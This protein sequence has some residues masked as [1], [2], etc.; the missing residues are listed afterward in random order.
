MKKN[1]TKINRDILIIKKSDGK[2]VMEHKNKF[3]FSEIGKQQ[4]K[5]LFHSK[6]FADNNGLV[7][8]I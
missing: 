4:K 7:C 8:I 3:R 2:K 1:A 5:E 6:P